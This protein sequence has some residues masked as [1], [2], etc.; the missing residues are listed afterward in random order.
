MEQDWAREHGL[1][2]VMQGKDNGSWDDRDGG[3]GPLWPAATETVKWHQNGLFCTFWSSSGVVLM[4][5]DSLAELY[6]TKKAFQFSWLHVLIN[7][8]L[9][10]E[11]LKHYII[12][13]PSYFQL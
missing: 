6:A 13:S 8:P 10:H 11:P 12:L 7:K 2:M 9:N 4:Y 5:A 1:K 3:N